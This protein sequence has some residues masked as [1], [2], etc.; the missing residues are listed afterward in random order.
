[1][2][3]SYTVAVLVEENEM[4]VQLETK[5]YVQTAMAVQRL[6][7]LIFNALTAYRSHK[8]ALLGFLFVGVAM[9]CAGLWE[10]YQNLHSP[11]HYIADYASAWMLLSIAACAFVAAPIW[12]QFRPSKKTNIRVARA[13]NQH[14]G[15]PPWMFKEHT[16]AKYEAAR[17]KKNA[18]NAL[19]AL[20]SKLTPET[21]LSNKQRVRQVKLQAAIRTWELCLENVET[22]E[23]LVAKFD[24]Q[25]YGVLMSY[26]GEIATLSIAWDSQRNAEAGQMR[27]AI[28]EKLTAQELERKELHRY[29]FLH[30]VFVADDDLAEELRK[31]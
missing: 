12:W 20:R 29:G 11:A 24:N 3:F 14:F 30:I 5:E 23:L 22:K 31:V 19:A 21:P 1:M 16:K 27:R 15:T 4:Y 2:L 13:L 18:A 26:S 9:L 17:R 10:V 8:D 28:A 7:G 25:M 6:D